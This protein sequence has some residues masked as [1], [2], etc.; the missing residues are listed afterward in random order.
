[1]GVSGFNAHP[2]PRDPRRFEDPGGA[3]DFSRRGGGV[4]GDDDEEEATLEELML[5]PGEV[6]EGLPMVAATADPWEQ[7][8]VMVSERKV[9]K[10]KQMKRRAR[11]ASSSR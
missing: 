2:L 11:A 8:R 5:L 3:V 1:M 7:P 4:D 10:K 6:A 9:N